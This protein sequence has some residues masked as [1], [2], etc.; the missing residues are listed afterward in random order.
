[1]P[2][3]EP[4][5]AGPTVTIPPAAT[6][7]PPESIF[8]WGLA[9]ILVG[10]LLALALLS[11][12]G[13]SP[14]RGRETGVSLR[15]AS[16]T[17]FLA[18]R[19]VGDIP[20]TLPE[21]HLLEGLGECE[22]RF[23]QGDI[24]ITAINPHLQLDAGHIRLLR[25]LVRVVFRNRGQHQ[26][27]IVTPTATIAVRGTVYQVAVGPAGETSVRVFEG[28]VLVT[29]LEG[30]ERLLGAGQAM[31]VPALASGTHP[32]GEVPTPEDP[33]RGPDQIATETEPSTP[34][35]TGPV[36]SGTSPASQPAI[37]GSPD[38]QAVLQK[39]P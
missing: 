15:V 34:S 21:G 14:N 20:T 12:P 5:H 37:D 27:R 8:R 31:D 7:T 39:N 9:A 3:D 4:L 30:P 33:D 19:A 10:G 18:G 29:P 32:S 22:L 1:M 35:G 13:E 25:G 17:V 28:K 23:E 11:R 24:T 26:F 16:G 36:G 38:P 6:S 2:H